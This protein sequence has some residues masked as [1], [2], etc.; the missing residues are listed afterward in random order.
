M[1]ISAARKY[2]RRNKFWRSMISDNPAMMIGID[3]PF[4]VACAN[5]VKNAAA[6]SIMM[7]FIHLPTMLVAHKFSARFPLWVKAVINVSVSTILMIIARIIVVAIFPN[8]SNLMGMYIYLIAVNGQTLIGAY[9][10]RRGTKTGAVILKAIIDIFI[11]AVV[12]FI[13]SA[14]REYFGNGSLWGIQLPILFKQQGMLYP[15]FG[16][17]LLG[18][19]VSFIRVIRK[20]AIISGVNS[21]EQLGSSYSDIKIKPETYK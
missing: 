20:K 5:S 10:A 4:I 14:M 19:L 7:L 3:L 17:V 12:M 11:F 6:L 1:K 2:Y 8:I 18:F 9:T 16:F 13:I 21:I 15:F